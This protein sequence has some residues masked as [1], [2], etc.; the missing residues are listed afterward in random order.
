MPTPRTES[1]ERA[2]S[3]LNAFSSQKPQLS[4]AEI[5][6]ETGLHKSTILRLINSM[7]L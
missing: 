5:A 1:V 2:L 7:T 6:R 3:I 4:L